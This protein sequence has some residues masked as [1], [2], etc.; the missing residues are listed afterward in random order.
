VLILKIRRAETALADARLDEAFALAQAP[1]LAAHHKGQKLIG[2][3]ARALADRGQKH[4]SAGRL[5]QASADCQKAAFLAG[6]L[7]EVAALRSAITEA[8]TARHRLE[9]HRGDVLAAA[10]EHVDH[11]RLSIGEQ[12]L[13]DEPDNSRIADLRDK[14][15]MRRAQAQSAIERSRQALDREDYAAAAIA[16]YE[17]QAV[18]AHE[19]QLAEMTTELVSAVCT[20]AAGAIDTGRLDLVESILEPALRVAG[21][22]VPVRELTRFLLGCREA[23]AGVNGGQPAITAEALQRLA[24]MRPSATWL[25]QAA[26][27]ARQA[28]ESLQTLRA[29]PLGLLGLLANGAAAPAPVV[30]G[31]RPARLLGNPV[32]PI[33]LEE[34]LDHP[35]TPPFGAAQPLPP[36]PKGG[37]GGCMNANNAALPA[38]LLVHVDGVGTYLLLRDRRVT[39]GP[40]GS[41]RQP[42][43]ALLAEP[44]LAPV[45]IERLDEDYFV[46][47]AAGVNVNGAA[48]QR[49]LLAN[50]D[51]I[52]V[53]PRARAR[54]VMPNAASTTAVLQLAGT[55]LPASDARQVILMDRECI[56]GP[57]ASA[58][59]R[60]DQLA[61]QAILQTRDGRLFCRS[62]E[63]VLVNE[64]PLDRHAGLPLGA[65]IQV[66]TV[67]FVVTA[68]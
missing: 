5:D 51:R 34:T 44:N 32:R 8:T 59:I 40:A 46:S 39:I 60:A 10:R 43:V 19:P 37:Q 21:D 38:K 57:G 29:G 20:R 27:D 36:L 16:L 67:S 65:R 7:P 58:H 41:S 25:T 31:G 9:R 52:T 26:R 47:C 33:H 28:A 3:L 17:A 23:F 22:S 56:L 15:A 11:G 42:D 14:V 55:R 13:A 66:G 45:T 18:H 30:G 6:S 68:A 2:R 49:K 24:A 63:T 48:A 35:A 53:S 1:D 64:K 54:F 4:L 12:C 62:K 50:G 61:D